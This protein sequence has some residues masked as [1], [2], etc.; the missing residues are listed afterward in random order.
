LEVRQF[1]AGGRG[2]T[3]K[4]QMT[5]EQAIEN[6]DALAK[7]IYYNLFDWL[8][9]KLNKQLSGTLPEERFIGVLDIYGFEVGTILSSSLQLFA[10]PTPPRT[11][12]L[13]TRWV[14]KR[15]VF[16]FLCL[17]IPLT[18]GL[19]FFKRTLLNNFVLIM[20]MKNYI[21][22]SIKICLNQNRKNIPK[23]VYH[24]LKLTGKIMPVSTPYPFS[25]FEPSQKHMSH[26]LLFRFEPN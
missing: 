24:G 20:Q 18:L 25:S 3:Y 2:T 5:E 7:S 12:D 1:S 16:L 10:Q 19:R 14:S 21:N 23:K 26:L 4:V 13:R 22:N 15:T 9:R 11:T 17:L 8:V 6:R